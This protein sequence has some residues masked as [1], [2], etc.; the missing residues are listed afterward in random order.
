[1]WV[2]QVYQPQPEGSGT[3]ND[4]NPH[5]SSYNRYRQRRYYAL[6]SDTTYHTDWKYRGTDKSLVRPGRKQATATKLLTFASHTKNKIQKVVRPTRSPRQQWPP[7]RKK[8]GEIS[9]VFL[10]QS[11]RANDLSAP[12]QGWT[13][14]L[15]LT[16]N[17]IFSSG[18]LA[19]ITSTLFAGKTRP[20]NL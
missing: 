13:F 9:V 5:I 15:Y 14:K 8:N 16:L 20:I 3:W 7:R 10:F 12:M 6:Y 4:G 1:M 18:V 17:F 2:F 11:G 19:L